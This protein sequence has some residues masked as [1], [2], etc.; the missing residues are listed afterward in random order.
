ML[1]TGRKFVTP[2]GVVDPKAAAGDREVAARD[3]GAARRARRTGHRAVGDRV[4]ED[5]RLIGAAAVDAADD[6]DLVGGQRA[7]DAEPG[8]RRR[9]RGVR[10]DDDGNR[11]APDVLLDRVEHG[12]GGV[13]A[14]DDEDARWRRRAGR[15]RRRGCAAG[16][17]PV[18]AKVRPRPRA[19]PGRPGSAG[20]GWD[21]P[22]TDWLRSRCCPRRRG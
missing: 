21:S 17:V 12:A 20:P 18:S 9:Q 10:R 15:W 6:V 22:A 7:A 13:L 8:A 16:S 3:P 19:R 5:R 1:C 14:A 2:G 11:L 4:L